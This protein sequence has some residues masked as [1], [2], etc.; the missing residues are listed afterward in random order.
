MSTSDGRVELVFSSF[1]K[2]LSIQNDTID[3]YKNPILVCVGA[4]DP[5]IDPANSY[6]FVQQRKDRSIYV[7]LNM[8]TIPF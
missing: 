6:D 4:K 3:H 2:D 1:L 5:T 7:S 8:R